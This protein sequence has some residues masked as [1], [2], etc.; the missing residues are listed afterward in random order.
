M[1]TTSRKE[2]FKKDHHKKKIK[3]RSHKI[4]KMSRV[5]SCQAL[6]L[7]IFNC[8]FLSLFFC[9]HIIDIIVFTRIS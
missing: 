6:S 4:T 2:E 7:S 9:N 8:I 1:I 3:Y 5:F